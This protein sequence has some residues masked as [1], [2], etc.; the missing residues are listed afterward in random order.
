MKKL[1]IILF[2]CSPFFQIVE[3]QETKS[4]MKLTQ[5]HQK[6]GKK[7]GV[8]VLSKQTF[9]GGQGGTKWRE[10]QCFWVIDGVFAYMKFSMT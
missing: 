6:V 9:P 1:F 5:N 3:S 2:F 8:S 4:K 10:S 7:H